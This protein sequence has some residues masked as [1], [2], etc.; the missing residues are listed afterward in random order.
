MI[1]SFAAAVH[2]PWTVVTIT[3]ADAEIVRVGKNCLKW[4][5]WRTTARW[6]DFE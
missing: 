3:F 5:S 1:S 2:A 4:K 6:F